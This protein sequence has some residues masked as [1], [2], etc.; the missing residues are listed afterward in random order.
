MTSS[1]SHH[2]TFVTTGA[3]TSSLWPTFPPWFIDLLQN[4]ASLAG[5]TFLSDGYLTFEGD[6]AS[7]ISGAGEARAAH[8]GSLARERFTAGEGALSPPV[9]PARGLGQ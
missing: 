4:D 9:I 3:T 8:R 1:V 7:M 6:E 2:V 5:F